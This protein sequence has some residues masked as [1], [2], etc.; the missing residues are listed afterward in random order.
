[1]VTS[2]V[3]GNEPGADAVAVDLDQPGLYA[4]Q[5]R[6]VEPADAA[7]GGRRLCLVGA[8]DGTAADALGAGADVLRAA[9]LD[10]A[11][12]AVTAEAGPWQVVVTAPEAAGE[13]AQRVRAGARWTLDTL[14]AWLRADVPAERA[15]LAFVTTD[16][17]AV[18][19]DKTFA[20]AHSALW[21]LVRS[22]QS[23]APGRFGL[24]DVDGGAAAEPEVL[25]AAVRRDEPQLAVRSGR[26]LVPQLAPHPVSGGLPEL[27]DG[28]VVITGGTG[29]LGRELA[30]HL[31]D[32]GARVLALISRRGEAT[33]GIAEF[34]QELA[35]RG[36]TVRVLAADACDRDELRRALAQVRQEHPIIGV[37]HAT[38]VLDDAPVAAT[39]YAQLDNHLGS[40]VDSALNLDAVTAEDRLRFF[41]VFSSLSGVLGGPGQGGYASANT[42]LD[43]FAAWRRAGGRPAVAVAWGLWGEASGLTQHLD[44]NAL[45]MLRRFGVAPFSTAAGMRMFDD[46]LASEVP[47]VVGA[48]LAFPGPGEPPGPFLL[49]ALGERYLAQR[50]PNAG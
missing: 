10:E 41:L 2:K 1:L 25:A 23:E 35:A 30:R 49:T 45:A 19:G 27:G 34:Q 12:A 9:D 32:G 44:E 7:G 38:G 13:T 31:V 28:A 14:Q 46:A 24:V 36:V 21:G 20:L 18:P 47:A 26:I 3:T 48:C 4:L 11:L 17:I 39:T 33:P 8:A 50:S 15:R 6:P 5:W 43:Q 37:A 42:F 16:S 22:A 29:T 40:K